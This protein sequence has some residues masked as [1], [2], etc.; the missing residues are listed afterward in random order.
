[1]ILYDLKKLRPIKVHD[2]IRI[3][4]TSDGGYIIS[5][6]QLEI[7]DTLLSFGI[8]TD[9]SFEEHY[10]ELSARNI[11]LYAFDGSVSDSIFKTKCYQYMLFT[12]VRALTGNI[13]KAKINKKLYDFYLKIT[14]DF[15]NFFSP[16]SNNYFIQKFLG[17]KESDTHT[18]IETIFDEYIK[19]GGG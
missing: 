6:A 7:T 12:I 16:K 2:L 17:S 11:K 5:K 10:K 8:S 19:K 13:S 9:W 4:K 14:K 1:M 18:N 15:K 3:G